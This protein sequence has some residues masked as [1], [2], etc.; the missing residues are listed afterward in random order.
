MRKQKF[1]DEQIAFMLKQVEIGASVG[2]VCRKGGISEHTFSCGAI[3]RAL[4]D[5]AFYQ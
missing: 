2:E 4:Q 3:H 5:G 1:T